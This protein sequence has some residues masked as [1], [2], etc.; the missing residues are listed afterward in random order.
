MKPLKQQYK[1]DVV[2][3]L[4]KDFGYTSIMQVPVL[5]K[6]VVNVGLGE[7]LDNAKALEY[8]VNDVQQITGQKPVITK[9][10]KSI[11]SFKLREGRQIG[12][13]VTLRGE[14]MWSFLTRL[15]HV[16]LPRTRDFQGV[17]PDSFDGR[18][19]YTLG[20]REQLIFPE[21]N[22]DKIDKVRGMEISIVTTA[23]TD[24]EGRRLLAHLGMPFRE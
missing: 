15:I 12:V 22:Y 24:E 14:R 5:E 6:I 1:E 18:G 19:N 16:A 3:A 4:M 9:A 7:A 8:A 23:R 10:K 13:K 20:L 11:A 2:P 17:S 21:I